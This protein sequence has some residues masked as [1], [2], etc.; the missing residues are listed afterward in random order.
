MI[1]MWVLLSIIGASSQVV[2]AVLPVHVWQLP[3]E[4]NHRHR[5]EPDSRTEVFHDQTKPLVLTYQGSCGLQQ[6]ANSILQ[7]IPNY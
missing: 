1:K 3:A 6:P 5:Y 4:A 7:S 2:S